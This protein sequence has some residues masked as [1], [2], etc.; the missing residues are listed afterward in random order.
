MTRPILTLKKRSSSPITTADDAIGKYAVFR[1]VA[2]SKSARFTSLHA[3]QEA[4]ENEAIRLH[5][6]PLQPGGIYFVVH[7]VDA[8]GMP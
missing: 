4:A 8:F 5:A 6:D 1:K 7:V 3:T 2:K